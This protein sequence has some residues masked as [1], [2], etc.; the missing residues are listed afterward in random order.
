[1]NLQQYDISLLKKEARYNTRKKLNISKDTFI[2]YD[3]WKGYDVSTLTNSGF[4][5]NFIIKV[6]YSYNSKYIINSKSLSDYW[7][8]FLNEKLGSNGK[9]VRKNLSNIVKSD[10][11]TVLETD[12]NIK[13]FRPIYDKKFII[14][15][16]K[17]IMYRDI[18]NIDNIDKIKISEYKENS[19]LLENTNKKNKPIKI[20]YKTNLLRDL[21][22]TGSVFIY[23]NSKKIPTS[24]NVIKYITSFRHETYYPEEI[25]ETIYTNIKNIFSPQQLSVICLYNRKDGWDSSIQRCSSEELLEDIFINNEIWSRL[26]RQ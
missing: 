21:N 20:G 17:K 9:E 1:M 22:N 23:I 24:R 5:L 25:C 3:I 12:V 10:F 16:I 26:A 19:T 8:G 6:T 18:D 2:G 13:I 11:E 7:K 14:N 4:P 15:P